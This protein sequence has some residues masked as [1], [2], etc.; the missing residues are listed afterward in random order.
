[1]PYS[2][3]YFKFRKSLEVEIRNYWSIA[4]SIEYS[5]KWLEQFDQGKKT[6]EVASNVSPFSYVSID[7]GDFIKQMPFVLQFTRENALVNF[8]TAF[9]VYLFDIHS[10]IIYLDPSLLEKSE[11][12]FAANEL[13]EG[14]STGNFKHWFSV[15]ITDKLIRNKQHSE[16]IK[17]IASL[18][19]CDIKPIEEKISE[20]NKW[21]Y[22]RNAI[23]HNGRM[24][25]NDLNKIWGE[26]FPSIGKKINIPSNEIMKLQKMAMTI[27]KVLDKRAN[28]TIIKFLD[29]E[30]LIRELF[31]R[32]GLT[33]H[34]EVAKILHK[35]F[36]IFAS[37]AQV[38]KAISFQ[39]R[40]NQETNEVDF[41]AILK[42]I[43]IQ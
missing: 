39:K 37:K 43:E 23:V 28:Q 4:S 1:M 29:A 34:N 42:Y 27:A 6:T 26:K 31:I 22:V 19:K 20:W 8:I 33:D 10:R 18:A 30:L 9:E 15:K 35:N 21:T 7:C 38:D 5:N 16:I 41:D 11:S 3:A 12:Q 24:V 25:S 2:I 32:H 36:S 14:M 13:I 40:T 17:K